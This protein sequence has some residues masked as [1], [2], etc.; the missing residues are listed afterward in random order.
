MAGLGK[1]RAGAADGAEIEAAMKLAGLAHLGAAIAL[2]EGDEAAARRHELID[3]G[4]HAAGGGRAEGAR[5]IALGGLGRAGVV[6]GVVPSELLTAL[7]E[8]GPILP[9]DGG[10]VAGVRM[11]LP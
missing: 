6:D 2:G 9:R 8:V 5:G 3:I 4:I 7:A 10:G 11:R 1:P